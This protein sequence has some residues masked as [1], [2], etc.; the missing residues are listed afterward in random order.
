VTPTFCPSFMKH[1]I[2]ITI[3]CVVG[4]FCLKVIAFEV[5]LSHGTF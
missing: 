5:P 3:D 4:A 1:S 2:S